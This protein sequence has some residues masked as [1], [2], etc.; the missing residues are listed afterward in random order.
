MTRMTQSVGTYESKPTTDGNML[1]GTIQNYR[2]ERL[3]GSGNKT[4]MIRS[5]EDNL[6]TKRV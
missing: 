5:T 6:D 1:F 2:L 4:K 3:S